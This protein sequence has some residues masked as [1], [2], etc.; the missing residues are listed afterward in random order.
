MTADDG[1]FVLHGAILSMIT[2]E[3]L[4][5]TADGY[6]VCCD[7]VSA[8]V[9]EELPEEFSDWPLIDCWENLIVPGFIST[10]E[11]AVLANLRGLG[12]YLS[13]LEFEA[14]Y[15][16]PEA[17]KL[18]SDREYEKRSFDAFI[19]T[20]FI[21]PVTRAVINGGSDFAAAARLARMLDET[22]LGGMV[23]LEVSDTEGTAESGLENARKFLK[24]V[25]RRR[26]A[27]V[28]P[29]VLYDPEKISPELKEAL[30][31]FAKEAGIPCL[32]A[33]KRLRGRQSDFVRAAAD[34]AKS[35][36]EFFAALT[37]KPGRLFGD[38]GTFEPGA[39][40]DAII[41]ADV[42]LDT[43]REL[44][45]AERLLR[46]LNFGDDRSVVGKFVNG[47]KVF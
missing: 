33:E 9:F 46:V 40:F 35:F 47:W 8:G 7:G 20:L 25:K 30:E 18:A 27:N 4:F 3:E 10:R 24:R 36:A 1:K 12:T 42:N 13:D 11:N 37:I 43:M 16:E 31:D 34:E 5:E 6:L 32:E 15:A 38:V 45:P 44:T 2:D 21:G 22:G 26:L 41:L 29:A 28:E 14:A 23:G 19:E 17:R 39:E